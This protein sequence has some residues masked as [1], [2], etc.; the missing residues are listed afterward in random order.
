MN[1]S[2]NKDKLNKL[3][4]ENKI[5]L[6]KFLNSGNDNRFYLTHP[7]KIYRKNISKFRVSDHNLLIETGRYKKIPS[8]QRLCSVCKI[9][10]DECHFFFKCKINQ[11]IKEELFSYYEKE[12]SNFI[13]K[14]DI[15][16][17]T[18]FLN[19]STP[20]DIK[21]VMSFI[22]QSLELRKGDS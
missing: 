15:E 1:T 20:N 22:N 10:D 11:K 4:E 13:S 8:E 7:N 3:N 5:F 14:N 21:A 17:L 19:P 9:L 12:D 16:K 18:L 6:Y 2:K